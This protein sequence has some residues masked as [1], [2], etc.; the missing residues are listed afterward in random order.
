M[1]GMIKWFAENHVAANL[2]MVFLLLAGFLTAQSVKIE[3]FPE[4][5]L[6]MIS[7]SMEYPGASPEEVEEAIVRRIEENIAG[8]AGIDRITSAARESFGTVT[9][10]V[11]DGWDIETLV[12]DVK[13]EVDRIRTFPNEAEKPVI[14]QVIRKSQVI[15]LA[16]FGDAPEWTIKN[17]AEKIKDDLTTMPGIT[18]VE[19]FGV[20]RG[21]I[22]I[23]ISES[24]LR[25]YGLTLDQVAAAVT[26]ESL[27]LPAGSIKSKDGTLMIRTKGRRY[28]ASEYSD[29]TIIRNP[30][31][32][33]VTLGQLADLSDG[34]EDTEL[35]LSTRG[36]PAV[37]IEIY[38]VADQ[39]ALG[40]ATSVKE[41]IAS[42]RDDLPEG[43]EISFFNDA[44]KIL[45]D[46]LSLLIRNM[47]LGLILVI[48][49]LGLFLNPK[50]AFWVTLGIPISFATGLWLLP[51]FGVSINLISLFAFILILGIVV[52]DAIVIGEN[53]YRKRENGLSGIQGAVDGAVQVSR[54]VIFAVLTTV[55]AFYPL[56][57]IPGVRGKFMKNIPI[58]VILV[59]VGSLVEALFILPGHLARS[60][61]SGTDHEKDNRILAF[62]DKALKRFIKGP[63]DNFLKLCLKWRYVVVAIGIF[64]LITTASLF[65]SGRM[66]FSLFPKI[67]ADNLVCSIVMPSSTPVEKTEEVLD[68]IENCAIEALKEVDESRPEH[69]SVM[70][71]YYSLI[72]VHMGG[73]G[74]GGA[75]TSGGHLA[76][77]HIQLL[78]GEER[79]YQASKLAQ[80]W[81]KKVGII[82]EAESVTFIGQLRAMDSPVEVHLSSDNHE[83]L[84]EAVEAMKKELGEFPGITDINDDFMPGKDELQLRL[85]PEARSLGLTLSDLA[86]Q[87]RSAFYGSEALRL[88]RG[89][90]EVKVLVRYPDKERKT[91]DSIDRMR[92]RIPGQVEVPFNQVAEVELKQ[93]YA[94]INRT[95]RRRVIAVTADIDEA[96]A[97]ASV[98]NGELEASI[99]PEIRH[100]YPEV[101]FMIE[102]AG[103]R[104][105]EFMDSVLKSFII[106]LFII[107]ALLAIPFKSFAQPAIVMVAI[108][109]G[110][111]GAIFGHIIMGFDISMMSLFGI[112]GLSGV[113]VN[114]SLVLIEATNRLRGNGKTHFEAITSAG[115]LRFRAIIL[116]SITTFGGLI[117]M[118]LERS[119]Q[120]KFL[121]PMA[122]GLG[123][124]VLFGTV[125]TLLLI[126][127]LYLILE[128]LHILWKRVRLKLS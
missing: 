3:T 115:K 27:D 10:E 91:L 63:Y 82:P 40:V 99:L 12:N 92:I 125:I 50:L 109:F 76:Q 43:I 39:S 114:D 64:T 24:T 112:V 74:P 2:L 102:G 93:G 11:I 9:I 7:I 22:H 95:D 126:P 70:K 25:R 87:V 18:L 53:I 17:L 117:P 111:V 51:F 105:K 42:I 34:F 128:D 79:D 103:R 113:V 104:D 62:T 23:D 110:I 124:G 72:G 90:D 71:E 14:R 100:Q 52:D 13:A 83:A 5:S 46:R 55:A 29:I 41:Y 31:G 6:D 89:I 16:L 123:Y 81:R 122:A 1:K 85:K 33:K 44:S 69:K 47:A 59:L 78:E 61:F 8:L 127:C 37:F 66:K 121:I 120:A 80:A 45:K 86:R 57:M 60:K 94:T 84:L 118:L 38:R 54:P 36:K 48:V 32:S 107:Y 96:Q 58:V 108:P 73:M 30:D 67:E 116:T 19:L 4:F 97:N 119:L 77:V 28:Y 75:S 15:N 68:Y 88:Q 21:E 56:L 106:A 98:V 49:I 20:K 65:T 26:R 35:T 101:R